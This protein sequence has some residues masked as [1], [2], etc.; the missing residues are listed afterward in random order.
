MVCDIYIVPYAGTS[1][2]KSFLVTSKNRF[3]YNTFR[4]KFKKLVFIEIKGSHPKRQFDVLCG[5]VSF[6]TKF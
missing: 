1:F 4:H 5:W 6:E 2:W 3:S